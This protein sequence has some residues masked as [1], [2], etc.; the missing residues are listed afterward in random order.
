MKGEY[1]AVSRARLFALSIG[2]IMLMGM[3]VAPTA[4]AVTSATCTSDGPTNVQNGLQNMGFETGSLTPWREGS[5]IEG[6]TVV[7][8]DTFGSTTVSP[9]E[10]SKMARLGNKAASSGPSQSPGPNEICQDFIVDSATEHLAFNIFTYDYTGF[11]N[12][13]FDVKVKDPATGETLA[14]YQQGA[15]G[16]GTNIKTTGWRGATLDLSGHVGETVRLKIEAGGT[17]DS[18]YAFWAYVDSADQGLPPELAPIANVASTTGSVMTDPSTG[19]VTVAM[20]GGN[21]SDITLTTKPACPD[22]GETASDVTLMLGGSQFPMAGP[23][24][25]GNYSV[26][27]PANQVQS[28]ELNISFICGGANYV[29]NIGHIQLYD[30]SGIVSNAATGDPIEGAEV[31]L[32]KVPGW[33]AKTGPSDN[34]ADTCQSN[35]SKAADDPWNQPAP[36][37]LGVQV[38]PLSPEIEPNVNPFVTNSIGYYGWDVAAGCWYVVVSHPGYQTLT[39]PVVGVP[40]EVTDLDLELQ[41]L[42]AGPP[43]GGGSE[44]VLPETAITVGPDEGSTSDSADAIFEFESTPFGSSFECS[45]DSG[46]FQACVSP[47][48]YSGLTDGSHTFSVRARDAN[49]NRDLTPATRTWTVGDTGQPA[50][51]LDETAPGT[52]ILSGPEGRVEKKMKRN[53][54]KVRFT[55]GSDEPNVTF[56]CKMDDRRWKSCESEEAFRLKKGKH[57]LQVRATDAAGNTDETPAEQSFRLVKRS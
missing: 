21:K 6:T 41:P 55:F 19:K 27:I 44:D 29:T 2:L 1:M 40:P 20:P 42:A 4:Q 53:R 23:D 54:A 36:T 18:L 34:A 8:A 14:Q 11:D 37:H 46:A 9:W 28:A 56:E 30:P 47:R 32:H 31:T 50:P 16:S 38:N 25:G 48:I 17:S 10:G 57:V 13:E 24:A 43:S 7:G 26:T 3:L 35:L 12:F 51:P 45:L 52:E 15:W 39:S 33:S 49:G 22:A 5:K